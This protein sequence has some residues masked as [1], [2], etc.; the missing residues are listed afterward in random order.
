MTRLIENECK[1]EQGVLGAVA[2][3]LKYIGYTLVYI[4][5]CTHHDFQEINPKYE[6]VIQEKNALIQTRLVRLPW[7]KIVQKQNANDAR[8]RKLLYK[9]AIRE[10]KRFTSIKRHSKA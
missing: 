3:C 5:I 10:R 8:R 9:H 6:N 4:Y 1:Y 7:K 2:I